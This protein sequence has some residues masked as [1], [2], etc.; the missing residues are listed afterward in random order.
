MKIT[1]PDLWFAAI[2]LW[3]APHMTNSLTLND[4]KDRL[5]TLDEVILLEILDISSE[6]LV[7]MFSDRIE[8]RKDY[9][10]KDLEVEDWDE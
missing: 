9:F 5:K 4:I 10:I 1:W 8:E 2:N 6:E 7:E 3:N